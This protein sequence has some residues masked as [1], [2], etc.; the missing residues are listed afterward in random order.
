MGDR[1]LDVY[2]FGRF[3]AKNRCGLCWD[4]L[5]QNGRCPCCC[6]DTEACA[7][8]RG[9]PPQCKAK[10]LPAPMPLVT[11]C[12]GCGGCKGKDYLQKERCVCDWRANQHSKQQLLQL[13]AMADNNTAAY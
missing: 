3:H 13:T 10:A 1:L 2:S 8:C 6:A 4:C 5:N 9:L 12:V 7:R 11:K